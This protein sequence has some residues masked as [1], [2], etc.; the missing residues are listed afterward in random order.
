[1]K[2]FPWYQLAR[3]FRNEGQVD[4]IYVVHGLNALKNL[5]AS[6]AYHDFDTCTS[7]AERSGWT[8]HALK[9][10]HVYHF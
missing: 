7:V 9:N 1:M 3:H 10:M 8:P 4:L 2:F 5:L 6:E